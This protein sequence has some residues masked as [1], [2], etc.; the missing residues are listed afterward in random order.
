MNPTQPATAP[1]RVLVAKPGLDGHDRGA[2]VVSIALARAGCEVIYSGLHKSVEEI[3]QVAAEEAVDVV[4]LSL[5]SGAHLE[6]L[7]SLVER[8]R[9]AGL[10]NVRVVVGGNI[11]HV[12]RTR[13]LELGAAAVFPTGSDLDEICRTVRGLGPRT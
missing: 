4:G 11:P 9:A 2:K 13:L 1:V 6:I 10:A 8:L 3:V 12:D 7:R 5:L